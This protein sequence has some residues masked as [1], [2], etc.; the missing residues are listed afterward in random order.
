QQVVA[1]VGL[2]ARHP[3]LR[4]VDVAEDDRL[5]GTGLLAG[6]D[7][8][9]VAD[10]ATLLVGGDARALDALH[11]VAALL[12]DPP[13]ADGDVGVLRHLDGLVAPVGVEE[14]VET[15]DLVGT[16]VRA[17]ARAD[18]AVVD[19]VVEALA[20]V[21]GGIHRAHDLARRVFAVHARH[22]LV[23]D[24]GGVERP[25][26]RAID[27]DP[28]HPVPAQHLVA[29]DHGNVVLG[30]A[31]ERARVAADARRQVDRHAPG[32]ARVLARRIERV[33]GAGHLLHLAREPGM[34]A[35]LRERADADE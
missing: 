27:P 25:A 33:V 30:R 28:G 23:D 35:V 9:A 13:R 16:V 5:G 24:L 17:V 19:H 21:H 3:A 7:D 18:A 10:R 1:G 12:H 4:I 20:A 22:R 6:G 32:V 11:A 31:R 14:V 29:P 8:L 15:P 26:G 2:Q 34:G